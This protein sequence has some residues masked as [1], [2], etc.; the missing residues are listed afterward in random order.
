MHVEHHPLVKDFPEKLEQLHQLRQQDPSF[1]R[2]AGIY[3]ALDKQICHVEDGIET[4][5]NETLNALKLERATLK[6]D[7]ARDLK[8]AGG[9]CSGGC[10]SCCG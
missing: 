4:L 6:D 2:K 8:R 5:D 3:E 10:S 7:I 1:A 9:S